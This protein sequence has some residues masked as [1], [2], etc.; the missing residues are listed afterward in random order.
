MKSLPHI[1]ASATLVAFK[2]WLQSYLG[3]T[4]TFLVTGHTHTHNRFTAHFPGPPGWAGA[5]RELLDFM[6]QRKINRGRHTDH[7]AGRHSIRT[8]QCP[9][10]PSPLSNWPVTRKICLGDHLATAHAAESRFPQHCVHCKLIV[11]LLLLLL[12][13]RS[14]SGSQSSL[15]SSIFG[16]GVSHSDAVTST[17]LF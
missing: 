12:W 2:C 5:R 15:W 10:P 13:H 11:L 1:K 6:V 3:V 16:L 9:P 17:S 14:A 8:D 4:L 7:P